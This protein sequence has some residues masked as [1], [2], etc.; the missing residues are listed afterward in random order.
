[1]SKGKPTQRGPLLHDEDFTIVAKYQAEFR[2]LVQYYLLAQDV[3][4]LGR[5][6]WVMETSMLKTLAGKHPSSRRPPPPTPYGEL[7]A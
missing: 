2:E 6:R 7:R 1:M 4:R 3:S 5:L